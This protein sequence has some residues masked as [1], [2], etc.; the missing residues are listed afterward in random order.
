MTRRE[1]SGI[2]RFAKF[3]VTVYVRSWFLA[4]EA[5]RAPANDIGLLQKLA[6]YTDCAIAKATSIGFSKHLWYLCEYLVRFLFFDQNVSIQVKRDMVAA[7]DKP[8]SDHP[9]K[10]ITIDPTASAVG[11]MTVAD[12]VT[13]SSRRLF[14]VLNI[15]SGFLLSDPDDWENRP[16]YRAATEL[17]RNIK[18]VNDMAERGVA[19]MQN[20]NKTLTKD[21]KQQQFILQVVERL[22]KLFPNSLKTTVTH[23]Q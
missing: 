1:Q 9:P 6:S 13:R 2:K 15:E 5:V 19:L 18:V 11:K 22:Q 12:F 17:V 20:F 16:D 4:P 7:L 3:A 23:R 10:R 8:G 21:E 14:E